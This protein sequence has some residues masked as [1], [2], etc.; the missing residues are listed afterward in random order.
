MNNFATII[1]HFRPL[2]W[3]WLRQGI[4]LRKVGDCTITPFDPRKTAAQQILIWKLS[5]DDDNNASYYYAFAI[6]PLL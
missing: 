3:G 6:P 1:L 4:K 2:K 5:K